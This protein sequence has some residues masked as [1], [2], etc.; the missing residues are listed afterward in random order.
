MKLRLDADE[1]DCRAFENMDEAFFILFFKFAH[2]KAD[3]NMM[4]FE[5]KLIEKK[6]K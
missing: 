3:L 5:K 4:K 1:G 6:G 2:W